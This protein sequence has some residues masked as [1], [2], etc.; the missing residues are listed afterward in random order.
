[1]VGSTLN[2]KSMSIIKKVFSYRISY[3]PVCIW[4]FNKQHA[5]FKFELNYSSLVVLKPKTKKKKKNYK[6]GESSL[7][8]PEKSTTGITDRVSYRVLSFEQT[9]K[10][11]IRMVLKRI[12]SRLT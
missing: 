11:I 5:V 6:V 7:Y 4:L 3:E 2:S 12:R 10:I 1:M 8:D 9:N